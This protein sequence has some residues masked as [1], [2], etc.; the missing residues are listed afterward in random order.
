MLQFVKTPTL[1]IACDVN[2]PADGAPV[3]LLHGWPYGPRTW[4][5][6]VDGLVGA[7]KRTIVPALRGFGATRFLKASTIR[8]GQYAA[9][10]QDAVDLLDALKIDRVTVVGHDWGGTAAYVLGSQFA[11]RVERMVVMSV[12]YEK[13]GRRASTLA[14]HQMHQY[15]YQWLWQTDRGR[16]ALDGDRRGICKYLW[17]HWSPNW[18]WDDA[19]FDA[20]ADAWSNPDWVDVTLHSYRARWRNAAPDP[21]YAALERAMDAHPPIT[22]PTTMLHGAEDGASLPD[23]SAGQAASFTAGYARTVIPIVGHHIQLERPDL[24]IDAALAPAS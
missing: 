11:S 13:K 16:E 1:D 12:G 9:I 15:W 7:G 22:V 3:L 8:A 2:G 23:G 10:A 4:D 6:V 18:Q 17:R 19:V 24:V 20:E 14:P 21:T 5:R